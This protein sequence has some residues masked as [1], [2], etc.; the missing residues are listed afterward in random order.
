[1]H[2]IRTCRV[3]SVQSQCI[4]A[5]CHTE[6]NRTAKNQ[7]ANEIN[8]LYMFSHSG[9][10]VCNSLNVYSYII[11]RAWMAWDTAHNI[12]LTYLSQPNMVREHG[13][14]LLFRNAIEHNL[15]IELLILLFCGLVCSICIRD[16]QWQKPQMHLFPS[17]LQIQAKFVLQMFSWIWQ[18]SRKIYPKKAQIEPLNGNNLEHFYYNLTEILFSAPHICN[19][20]FLDR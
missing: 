14:Q 16:I 11:H 2:L 1:M 7:F 15:W 12:V 5:D 4:Y 20:W 6:T 10:S 8:F 19:E 9:W 3:C 13:M 18:M 17:E